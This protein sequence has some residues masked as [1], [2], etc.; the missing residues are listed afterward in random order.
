MKLDAP[1]LFLFGAACL[2]ISGLLPGPAILDVAYHDTYFVIAHSHMHWFMAVIFSGCATLYLVFTRITGRGIH[3]PLA[4]THFWI[5]FAGFYV[6]LVAIYFDH[7]HQRPPIISSILFLMLV[8][9][10]VLLPITLV[11]SLLRRRAR[12]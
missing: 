10:Q 8:L 4:R 7:R 9:A 11:W 3:E 12:Q 2:I 6:F 1:R 5:T